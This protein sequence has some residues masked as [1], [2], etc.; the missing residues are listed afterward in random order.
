MPMN[1]TSHRLYGVLA[2]ADHTVSGLPGSFPGLLIPIPHPTPG[3]PV[4]ISS[5][6]CRIHLLT[7]PIR[8]LYA[9]VLFLVRAS[10]FGPMGGCATDVIDPMGGDRGSLA[11]LADREFHWAPNFYELVDGDSLLGIYRTFWSGVRGLAAPDPAE[12]FEAKLD[13]L[14]NYIKLDMHGD[15]I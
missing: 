12:G 10:D 8:G 7:A 5:V 3:N 1:N 14:Y 2:L 11:F 6:I 4:G 13:I 15:P 9:T